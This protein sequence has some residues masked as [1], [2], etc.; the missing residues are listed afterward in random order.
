MSR[1][2][3]GL[4]A[5]DVG[6]ESERPEEDAWSDVRGAWTVASRMSKSS[7]SAKGAKSPGSS[8][9]SDDGGRAMTKA[10]SIGT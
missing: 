5:G 2:A 4:C 9:S 3:R 7:I 10:G 8:C 1:E 6:R